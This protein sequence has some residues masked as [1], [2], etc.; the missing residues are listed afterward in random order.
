MVPPLN[1]GGGAEKYFIDLAKN[2]SSNNLVINVVTMDDNF[3]RVFSRFIQIYYYQNFFRKIIGNRRER[4]ETV[5]RNLGNSKWIKSSWKNLRKVLNNYDIIYTKNELV[6]LFLLKCLNFN[7]LPPII[8]G[9]HTPI[10]YPVTKSFYSKFHN[11]LYMGPVYRFLIKGTKL[12]HAPNKYTQYLFLNYFKVK[13][14]LVYYPFSVNDSTNQIKKDESKLCFNKNIYNIAFVSRLS[15]QKG[16]DI[17]LKIIER[18]STV[19][20]LTN[21]ISINIFGSGDKNYE[22][23][24]R[25]YENK[26][27]F[28]RYYGHVENKYIPNI[29]SK[30]SLFLS[31][32]RW[33]VLPYN[34]LEAQAVG[35]PV[36]AFDIPGPNDIVDNNKTGFLV[37]SEEEFVKKILF[38]IENRHYLK[39][40][41]VKMNIFNKFNPKTIYHQLSSMFNESL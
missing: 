21:K 14:K 6:D 5:I 12:I 36:I 31:T 9:V 30:H 13:T 41:D 10:F 20:N 33:E 39:T 3:I 27:S 26:Y 2:L 23:I 37:N 18:L 34:I 16:V 22:E 25:N 8:V 38:L 7:K 17:L 19:P 11:F 29:L 40:Q 1:H 32:S 35:L 4:E 24:L 28:I 15:E